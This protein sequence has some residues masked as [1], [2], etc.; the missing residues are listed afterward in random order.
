M[1]GS[2]VLGTDPKVQGNAGIDVGFAWNDGENL[3]APDLVVGNVE[4]VPGCG[5][6]HWLEQS[7]HATSAE[8]A[9]EV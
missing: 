1:D 2:K 3:R 5:K 7:L 6:Q 8:D 9:V 4:R